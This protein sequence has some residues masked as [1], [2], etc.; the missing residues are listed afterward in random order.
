MKRGR[1]PRADELDLWQKV[2]RTTDRVDLAP[3]RPEETTRPSL[4]SETVTPENAPIAPFRVGQTATAMRNTAIPE[5]TRKPDPVRMDAKAFRSLKRGRLKPEARIDLHGMTLAEAHP[6]LTRF[7]LG[8]YAAGA[9]LVLVITGKG[10]DK[11]A[12]GEI[13]PERRGVLRRQVPH[14]LAQAPVAQCV[15]QV[16]EASRKHGGAGAFYVY[17]RRRR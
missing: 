5:S 3:L 11:T 15:L 10:G 7:I 4:K 6:A 14:W 12:S 1:H 13:M 9:R 17:L 2:A 8:H 16:S